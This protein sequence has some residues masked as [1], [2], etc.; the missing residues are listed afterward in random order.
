M[1][2]ALFDFD[3]TITTGDT[4]TPF[5]RIAV[6]PRRLMA[7]QL[8]LA[9]VV[10]GYRTGII[11][12]SKGRELAARAGFVGAEAAAVQHLGAQY[13]A[14]TLPSVIRRSAL[15]RIAWH[16]AQGDHIVVVSASLDAYLAPWCQQHGLDY[17]CTILEHRRGRLTGRYVD[18]DCAGFEKVRRIRARFDLGQYATLYAYGDSLEDRHMLELA[19]KKFYRGEE[20]S[21][22]ADVSSFDHPRPIARDRVARFPR[23]D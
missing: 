17:I 13:A 5:M 14:T 9:P 22:W 20:I 16:R 3:G 4:W 21:S 1:N 10:I 6:R 23:T 15:D 11:S 8:L 19:D 7:A 18:G 2:I 12:A